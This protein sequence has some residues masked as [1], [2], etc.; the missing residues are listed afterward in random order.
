[1]RRVAGLAAFAAASISLFCSGLSLWG[2]VAMWPGPFLQ[3]AYS[4]ALQMMAVLVTPAALYALCA[5]R[6]A[7]ALA[8]VAGQFLM[9]TLANWLPDRG[10]HVCEWAYH[11]GLF[12]CGL[13]HH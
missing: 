7:A 1:M 4:F 5:Q 13:P 6:F 12:D 2:I 3:P 10:P 8:L 9:F 11:G